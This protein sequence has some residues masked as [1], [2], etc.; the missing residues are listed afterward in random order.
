M[1]L[2]IYINWEYFLGIIS[3]LIGIAY[4]TNGRFTKLETSVECHSSLLPSVQREEVPAAAQQGS[5]FFNQ[6]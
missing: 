3:A 5:P 1:G 4:Y 6:L 2:T